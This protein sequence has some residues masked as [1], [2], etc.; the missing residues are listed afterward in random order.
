[1]LIIDTGVIVAAADRNDRKHQ[2]CAEFLDGLQDTLVTTGL[3]IAEACYLI[4]R[5]LGPDSEAAFLDSIAA[6]DLG[7]EPLGDADF[8]RMA[9]LVRKY[10]DL[11]LGATDASVVA[12]AERLQI[13]TVATLDTHFSIVRP[14]H[15]PAFDVVPLA[16]SVV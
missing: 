16:Q 14:N 10:A 8:I 4:E 12:V 6:G 15:R 9:E 1:M 3:V 11:G 7:V 5:E 13:A 2:I